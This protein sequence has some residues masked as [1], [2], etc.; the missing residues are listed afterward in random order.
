MDRIRRWWGVQRT[1]A[2]VVDRLAALLGGLVAIVAV[3]YISDWSTDATGAA[4]LVGSMGASA[5]LLFGAHGGPLSQPWPLVGGHLVA[6][7]VG[8]TVSEL[9][10]PRYLA[11]GLAVGLAIAVM[12][13]LG[14]LHP[15]GGATALTAVMGGEA[16]TSLG[17][18]FVVRPVL[19]NA[20][21]L[22][23]VGLVFHAVV[24]GRSYPAGAVPSRG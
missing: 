23:V 2:S 17:Y 6:A 20:A 16:V 10:D 18:G 9:V 3:A 12:Q 14:C 5:V 4:M 19:L 13:L 1:T 8:V 7:V 22:L 15:P 11:A 21:V 24:P